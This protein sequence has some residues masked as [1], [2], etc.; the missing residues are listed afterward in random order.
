MTVLLPKVLFEPIRAAVT[1]LAYAQP[2]LIGAGALL[3]H[4]VPL[5]LTTKDADF[6]LRIDSEELPQVR[7]N[8]GDPWEVMSSDA[9]HCF[10]TRPGGL[11]LD[12]VPIGKPSSRPSTVTKNAFDLRGCD[13]AAA[14]AAPLS[15]KSRGSADTVHAQVPP[16]PVLVLLKVIAMDDSPSTREKDM[17][18]VVT[19]AMTYCGDYFEDDRLWDSGVPG[20]LEHTLKPT[21]LLGSDIGKLAPEYSR[22]VFRICDSNE[23]ARRVSA[24][25]SA[26]REG[27]NGQDFLDALREGFEAG[28]GR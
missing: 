22:E 19:V 28:A 15:L 10:T 20:T 18:H 11:R 4:G 13:L 26:E 27:A 12:V 8:L 14:R 23:M 21:W 5:S 7:A 9:K 24:L 25:P 17:S 6:L 2:T 16:I 3:A 1:K